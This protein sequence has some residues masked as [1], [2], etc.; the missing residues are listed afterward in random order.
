MWNHDTS[1]PLGSTKT[2]TLRFN[3]GDTTGLNYDIDLPNNTWGNDVRESVQ[4]GDVD[5][6]SFGFICLEDIW[7]KVQ[8]EGKEMYKRS[9]VKAELLE[10]SPCTFP[11]YDS[12]QINCRSF[13][14]MKA[15]TK[16]EKRLEELR[17]EAR[18]LEIA[19]ENNK[20]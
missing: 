17:K 1:C 18:L 20:E 7:S 14:R 13:E 3:T 15:D 4:R 10:V 2:D 9:V 8:H 6:S 11:A 16:E 19:D 12:S 5:G